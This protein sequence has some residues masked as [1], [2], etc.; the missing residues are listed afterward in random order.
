MICHFQ[1]LAWLKSLARKKK[2]FYK[3]LELEDNLQ[4]S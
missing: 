2:D 1:C 3:D 4:E